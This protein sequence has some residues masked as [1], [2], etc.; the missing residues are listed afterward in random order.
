M[1]GRPV[2]LLRNMNMGLDNRERRPVL[3][4]LTAVS[5][6]TLPKR[7]ELPPNVLEKPSNH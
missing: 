5:L 2:R 4:G 7:S 3:Q 1:L 6:A